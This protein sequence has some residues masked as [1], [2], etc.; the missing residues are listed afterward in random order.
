MNSMYAKKKQ[1]EI[2]PDKCDIVPG[3]KKM[4]EH[5][6]LNVKRH[7]TAAPQ[8]KAFMSTVK[9]QY[10]SHFYVISI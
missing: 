9:C 8:P 10:G 7:E 4:Y 5:M 6:A 3:G 1:R 2:N